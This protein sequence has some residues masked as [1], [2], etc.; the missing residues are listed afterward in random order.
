MGKCCHDT[1]FGFTAAG[2][3]QQRKINKYLNYNDIE[4]LYKRGNVR[5]TEH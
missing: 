5:R 2:H 1:A 4:N 3:T